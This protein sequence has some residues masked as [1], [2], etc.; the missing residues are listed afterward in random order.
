MKS[1]ILNFELSPDQQRLA[2]LVSEIREGL[3]LYQLPSLEKI[4]S[5]YLPRAA[6]MLAFSEDGFSLALADEHQAELTVFNLTSKHR[7][8]L[9]LPASVLALETG[10]G[11]N[12]LLVRS[13]REVLK[14]R[15]DPLEL[16]ERDAR[17]ELAFGDQKMLVDP[18][19]I[20][21]AHGVP[22]PL[23]TPKAIAMSPEGLAGFLANQ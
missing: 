17:I 2:V 19:E 20:C 23:F 7:E 4:M 9:A 3:Q 12:E 16:L 13:E 11:E 18:D 21:F 22:H 15:F 1:D 14:L 6:R 8:V 10:D 5:F